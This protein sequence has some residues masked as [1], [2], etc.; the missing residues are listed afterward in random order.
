MSGWYAVVDSG[1]LT[2]KEGDMFGGLDRWAWIIHTAFVLMACGAAFAANNPVPFIDL[3][4]VPAAA[5]PG[6]PGLTLTV[7]GAGFV[8][9]SVV[10]W[11]GSPRT[12]TFVSAGQ[13]TA[14]ILASDIATAST[15]RITVSNP[16]PG[17]GTSSVAYFEVTNPANS[18]I[19]AG[20]Q[21]PELEGLNP[22]AV[23]ASDLNNDGKLDLIVFLQNVEA[24][25]PYVALGNGDGTF[26]PLL[27]I[28]NAT[29]SD[30]FPATLPVLGDFNK[31]GKLDLALINFDSSS[32]ST[33]LGNG[34]GT[35]QPPIVTQGQSNTGYTGLTVGDFNQDGNLDIIANYVNGSDSGISLWLGN[36]DG[37]FQ[38]PVN[39]SL[40][41]Y[42]QYGC[43]NAA[44]YNDDG[45]LDLLCFSQT[46][47]AVLPGNGDGTFQAAVTSPFQVSPG[48]GFGVQGA[49][50]V[51][52]D[53][54]LDLLLGYSEDHPL[55]FWTELQ[56]GNGDGSFQTA[57]G[58]F[59]GE[60]SSPPADFN[61]DGKLDFVTDAA[62]APFPADDLSI[63]IGNGDG[64]FANPVAIK[65]TTGLA[66]IPLLQGDFNGDGKQ[67]L[68]AQDYNGGGLWM[69]LQGSFGAGTPSPASLSFVQPIGFKSTGQ[70]VTFTNT[71]TSPLTLSAMN[72]TG[73]NATEFRQTNSCPTSLA[74]GSKCQITVTFAPAAVGTR[75]ATLNV[76]NS[77]IGSK[78][79]PLSGVGADFSLSD[80]MP[81]SVTVAAG[82]TAL[83]NFEVD[84]QDGFTGDVSLSCS[85]TPAGATCLPA[86]ARL[87]GSS[88]KAE[89]RVAT[90]ARTIA[91]NRSIFSG[92]GRWLACG[93]FGLPLIVSLA[94]VGVRRPRRDVCRWMFL[95]LMVT[96]MLVWPACGGGSGGGSN[97]SGT[98]TGTYL[99]TVAGQ[100]TSGGKTLTRNLNLTLVVE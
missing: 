33:L 52:G 21:T 99:L 18:I 75:S 8:N 32:V 27:P 6:G 51:N 84:A 72:I 78:V 64:T 57:T 10:N 45:K 65:T 71:G 12:T 94:R 83:F 16:A 81:P 82:Q 24:A 97:G 49:F 9:G 47:V 100:Y 36:G 1:S 3:P 54:K 11:N 93:L 86:I 31:D 26:Q 34:D 58:P 89:V 41:I 48:I 42:F 23:L 17:G 44:D 50:D 56:L 90:T 53:G 35:F 14:A 91:M 73:A 30:S 20:L 2:L 96:A 46:S 25:N 92:D 59:T 13:I 38:S 87:N 4:V 22:S 39:T 66:L 95:S 88:V 98:P 63:W 55:E 74:A 5:V 67:D 80:P 15:A 28:Q 85:A 68:L 70:I 7:N 37:T 77:G 62:L 69:F 19:V 40:P 43:G 79:V 76:P 60:A 29:V 61:G